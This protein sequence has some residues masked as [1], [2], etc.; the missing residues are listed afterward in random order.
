MVDYISSESVSELEGSI[1]ESEGGGEERLRI[2]LSTPTVDSEAC[3]PL[4]LAARAGALSTCR[5]LLSAFDVVTLGSALAREDSRGRTALHHALSSSPST[6]ESEQTAL[7]LLERSSSDS[8]LVNRPAAVTGFT[9]LH[10]AV[11]GGYSKVVE[12]LL[13][14]GA[15]MFALDS[16]KQLPIC[17]G[18]MNTQV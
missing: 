5:Y 13:A 8:R 15:N 3:S 14:R 4:M 17:A 1:G 18:A 7:L 11:A 16:Q 2:L 9:P 12:A 6:R 10:L